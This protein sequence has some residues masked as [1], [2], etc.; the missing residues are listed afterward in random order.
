MSEILRSKS[1][2]DDEIIVVVQ[3]HKAGKKIEERRKGT[4]EWY[5]QAASCWNF[6][7]FEYRVAPEPFRCWAIFHPDR[8]LVAAY[9]ETDKEL[10]EKLLVKLSK[11]IR[12]HFLVHLQEIPQ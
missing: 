5:V 4:D 12:I 8:T 1:M 11:P 3:G 6:D 10:A 2:S 9:S 7:D